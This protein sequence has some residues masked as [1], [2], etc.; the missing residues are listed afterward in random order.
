M[1][2]TM[3]I[4]FVNF[5]INKN[6][7]VFYIIISVLVVLMGLEYFDIFKISEPIGLAFNNLYNNSYLVVI[8]LLLMIGL[9]KVNFDFISKRFLFR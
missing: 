1:F 6:N 3:A 9:Y 8:P 4:N 7:T 2:L 5:L